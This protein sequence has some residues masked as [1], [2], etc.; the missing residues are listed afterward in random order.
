MTIDKPSPIPP[1]VRE[2]DSRQRRISAEHAVHPSPPEAPGASSGKGPS[3]GLRRLAGGW[4][5]HEFKR[6]EN[7]VAPLGEIDDEP[8]R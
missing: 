2:G 4:S 7:A 5:D 6:F 1:T 8:W 3:N